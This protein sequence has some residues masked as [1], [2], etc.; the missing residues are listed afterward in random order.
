MHIIVTHTQNKHL[1]DRKIVGMKYNHND[2]HTLISLCARLV[3]NYVTFHGLMEDF[4]KVMKMQG[5][6]K[7]K[8]LRDIKLLGMRYHHYSTHTF[9][10]LCTRLVLKY[11]PSLV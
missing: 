7:L 10:I 1:R 4:N 8:H 3:L 2:A 11:E 5:F 6:V 9:I